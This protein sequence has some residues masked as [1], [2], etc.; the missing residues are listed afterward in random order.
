MVRTMIRNTM[1]PATTPIITLT[2]ELFLW[3][4]DSGAVV[5]PE[6]TGMG[7]FEDEDMEIVLVW[8][9]LRRHDVSFPS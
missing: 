1:A 4:V 7:I 2:C 3:V 5:A 9:V 8:V 6:D